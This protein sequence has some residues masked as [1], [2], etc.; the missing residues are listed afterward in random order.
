[1]VSR[2]LNSKVSPF[3]TLEAMNTSLPPTSAQQPRMVTLSPG[4]NPIS[5]WFGIPHRT[6]VDQDGF[7]ALAL[8]RAVPG[9]MPGMDDFQ[10]PDDR[11][12]ERSDSLALSSLWYGSSRPQPFR[13]LARHPP[14]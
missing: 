7:A 12:L 2:T 14:N 1:M 9:L 6:E 10:H 5:P 3:L 13:S 11:R 4:L 8:L